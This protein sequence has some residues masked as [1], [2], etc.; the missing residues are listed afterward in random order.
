L[1]KALLLKMHLIREREMP[2]RGQSIDR[3]SAEM[4][5]ESKQIRGKGIF[6]AHEDVFIRWMMR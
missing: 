4:P 5:E 3:E 1:L 2:L 6:Q